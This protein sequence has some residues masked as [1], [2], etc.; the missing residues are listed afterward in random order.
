[1]I[2]LKGFATLN[3]WNADDAD[4]TGLRGKGFRCA[5]GFDHRGHREGTEVH[6]EFASLMRLF[7]AKAQGRKGGFA[8][9]MFISRSR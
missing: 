6:R 1:M 5:H 9:L 7:H 4:G 2:F 8:S 3:G